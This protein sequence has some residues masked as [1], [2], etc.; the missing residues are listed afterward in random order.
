MPDDMGFDERAY[1]NTVDL[2]SLLLEM[3]ESGGSDLHLSVGSPPRARI[4][5]LLHPMSEVPLTFEDTKKLAY[6]VLTESQKKIFEEKNDL[7]FSFGIKGLSRFRANV[8][9][10]KGKVSAAFRTIPYEIRSF[11]DLGLPS[12][13]G[14]LCERPRGLILVTGP[15]GSGKSTTLAA[16]LDKINRERKEHII[17]IED[18]IEYLHEHKSCMVDQREVGSDTESFGSALRAALRQDPDVVLVGEMRDLETTETALRVAETG[19]LTFATLHTNS[20]ASTINR[21]ID[22]FPAHQQ[23]QIR[24]QLALILEGI[25]TQALI[26]NSNGEGRSLALEILIP[27]PGIRNLIRE[28]KIHQ[29]YNS[30]QSSEAD[31]MKTFNRSL[32]EL[33][34]RKKITMEMALA[35]SS[36]QD[37]LNDLVGKLAK[38]IA[39]TKAPINKY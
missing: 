1:A 16:M 2:A 34:N 23:A 28:D 38:N 15:T 37:E 17:T 4:H 29:I 12:S 3:V 33:V 6:S 20:A 30:M 5:G 27:S 8:Y 18:P 26:P 21:I 22:I 11:E 7:D 31:G 14:K 25:L 19:H 32:A 36:N 35:R 39:L 24:T 13:I 10:Q 9:S